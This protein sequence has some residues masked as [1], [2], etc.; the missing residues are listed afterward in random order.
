MLRPLLRDPNPK[1]AAHA[2][3]LLA[4]LQDA[5]GLDLLVRYWRTQ[6]HDDDAWSG[7]VYGAVAALTDDSTVLLLKEIYRGSRAQPGR[8]SG[9][10]VLLDHSGHGR[11]CCLCTAQADSE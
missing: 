2:A 3:Y 1:T 11:P 4:L 7:L 10:S 8:Q 9:A 5:T 6:A